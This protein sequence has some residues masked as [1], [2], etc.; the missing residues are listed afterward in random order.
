[1]SEVHG[2]LII[3]QICEGGPTERI[4]PLNYIIFNRKISLKL[5]I[6]KIDAVQFLQQV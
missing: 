4:A 6:S 2:F 1:M 5:E 3:P